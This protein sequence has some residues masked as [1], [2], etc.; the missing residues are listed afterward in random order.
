MQWVVRRNILTLT[1]IVPF[2]NEEKTLESSLIRLKDS[3]IAD[4]VILI[5]DCSTDNSL[6]IA[7]SFTNNKDWKLYRNENN[8]GKGSAIQKA[9]DFINSD[10]FIVHD[11]DLE[12]NPLDIIEL[13][14]LS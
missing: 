1:V 14:K 13:K 7:Q 10:L 6:N 12:Y 2:Y 4:E 11:A 3:K 9:L 5:D 8:L